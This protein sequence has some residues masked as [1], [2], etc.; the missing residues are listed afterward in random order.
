MKYEG[1]IESIIGGTIVGLSAQ[2]VV[3]K[4]FDY[5]LPSNMKFAAKAACF[6]GSRAVRFV[7]F[8]ATYDVAKNGVDSVLKIGETIK[9]KIQDRKDSKEME[10]KV[11]TVECRE[12]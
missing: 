6:I 1:R 4:V 5:A 3:D 11:V 8:D 10:C 7:V 12:C 2:Y 9:N